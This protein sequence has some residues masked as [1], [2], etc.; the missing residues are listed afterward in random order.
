MECSTGS[1]YFPVQR[2]CSANSKNT[3]ANTAAAILRIINK[4]A[5]KST[6]GITE[7]ANLQDIDIE[8]DPLEIINKN[9]DTASETLRI[10]A[11]KKELVKSTS[12]IAKKEGLQVIGVDS[13]LLEIINKKPVKSFEITGKNSSWRQVLGNPPPKKFFNEWI[14]FQ[15]KKWNFQRFLFNSKHTKAVQTHDASEKKSWRQELGNPP[16]KKYFN[17]WILF[18]KEKWN[19]Q[20]K[21]MIDLRH[22]KA[23]MTDSTNESLRQELGNP[24][25]KKYV[26][27]KAVKSDR[28]RSI[29]RKPTKMYGKK[30]WRQELGNPPLR[31]NVKEWILFQKKKWNFQRKYLN[32]LRRVKTLMSHGTV[33]KKVRFDLSGNLFQKKKEKL[34]DLILTQ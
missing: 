32:D 11:N 21:Q 28:L 24:T 8:F 3:A 27:K 26:N 2:E 4:K 31:K 14:L 25:P 22:K 34:L 29:I 20:R 5:V 9:A 23:L 15:K 17:E 18:Q 13:E 1:K 16:P 7:K 6:S 10:A 30:S 12:G 19:F 33:E